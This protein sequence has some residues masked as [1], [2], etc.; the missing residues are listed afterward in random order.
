V[1]AIGAVHQKNPQGIVSLKE[2]GIAKPKDLEGKTFGIQPQ[3]STY[4]FWLAFA[5]MNSIDRGKVREFNMPGEVPVFILEKRV[6]GAAVLYDNE[7]IAIESKLAGPGSANFLLGD[8]YGFKAYGHSLFTG[9]KMMRER[10]D[11]VRRFLAATKK[12]MQYAMDHQ[13]EAIDILVKQFRDLNR[14]IAERQLAYGAKGLFASP[15]TEKHGL[16]WMVKE[17]W[18]LGQQVMLEQKVSNEPV[19]IAKFF[20]TQFLQ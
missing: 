4:P 16:L 18:D 19:D 7:L 9:E 5:K 14:T 6:Q 12:G 15:D 3:A 13:Q 1:V 17:R 8:D 11:V 2:S 20:T 10:P